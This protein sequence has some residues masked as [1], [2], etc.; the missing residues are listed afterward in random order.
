MSKFS[1]MFLELLHNVYKGSSSSGLSS[2]YRVNLVKANGNIHA[3]EFNKQENYWSTIHSIILIYRKIEINDFSC[4]CFMGNVNSSSSSL[5]P[6]KRAYFRRSEGKEEDCLFTISGTS[7][8]VTSLSSPSYSSTSSPVEESRTKHVLFS[9]DLSELSAITLSAEH[10]PIKPFLL[11]ISCSSPYNKNSI[12]TATEECPEEAESL[13]ADV[14]YQLTRGIDVIFKGGLFHPTIIPLTLEEAKKGE[15]NEGK[16]NILFS[17]P[18]L[19]PMLNTANYYNPEVVF[20][21]V[22]EANDSSMRLPLPASIARYSLPIISYVKAFRL[23]IKRAADI[24][25]ISKDNSLPSPYCIGY[26]LDGEANKMTRN[27]IEHRTLAAPQTLSPVWDKEMFFLADPMA[28]YVHVKV[29]NHKSYFSKEEHIG[30][31]SIPVD[32]FVEGV[33][34]HLCL[35]LEP[36][37]RYKA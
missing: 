18:K 17:G 6:T 29:R 22:V 7:I 30:Q 25:Y 36:T 37:Y 10:E 33:E 34:A 3:L 28:A 8:L 26:L 16:L 11:S 24:D 1:P 19:V 2:H 14:T 27:S 4:T 21:P 13:L 23:V 12:L 5:S 32:C 9:M 31:V 15:C 20:Q 35:P